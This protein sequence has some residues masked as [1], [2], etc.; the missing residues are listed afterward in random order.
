MVKPNKVKA[1]EEIL[2]ELKS[3]E[4]YFLM[5]HRGLTVAEATELRTRLRAVDAT[6]MVVKNTL[7]RRAAVEAGVEGMDELF[8]GPSAVAF[9]HGDPVGP[10]KVLQVFI[11]EKKKFSVKGGYLQRRVLQAAQVDSLAT[12]PSR[13]ELVA[14]VVGGIA[15]PLYGLAYVLSAPLRGLVMALDQIREQKAQAA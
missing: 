7:A 2:T 1:V 3:S 14:K 15:A 12:L 4:I 10:A 8:S 13:E 9:C 6:L 5:D 11:R